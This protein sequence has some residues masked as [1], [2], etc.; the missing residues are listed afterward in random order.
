VGLCVDLSGI[1]QEF[2][3]GNHR[4]SKE[5]TGEILTKELSPLLHYCLRKLYKNK[6]LVSDVIF[7]MRLCKKPGTV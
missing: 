3:Q 7:F 6:H 2:S 5:W 1:H 4:Q